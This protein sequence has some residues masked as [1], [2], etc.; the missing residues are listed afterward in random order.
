MSLGGHALTRLLATTLPVLLHPQT[1]SEELE[2]SCNAAACIGQDA[3]SRAGAT[4][5]SWTSPSA[6]PSCTRSCL[7]AARGLLCDA[8][9][10]PAG[11]ACC[12]DGGQEPDGPHQSAGQ[13]HLLCQERRADLLRRDWRP[14][15]WRRAGR[16]SQGAPGVPHEHGGG[17][18]HLCRGAAVQQVAV[19]R[20]AAA[21]CTDMP[22][23]LGQGQCTKAV[24]HCTQCFGAVH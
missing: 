8:L 6:V 20:P 22:R 7:A 23:G 4:T 5:T 3:Q 10:T 17:V 2:V 21:K 13:H 18:R 24:R 12:A 1:A 15:V 11:V 16:P 19:L 14:A 9:L